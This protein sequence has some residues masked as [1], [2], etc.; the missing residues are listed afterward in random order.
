MNHSHILKSLVVLA[1]ILTPSVL[2]AEEATI[3]VK[4]SDATSIAIKPFGGPEGAAA[5]KIVQNDLDLSGAFLLTPP[6]RASFSVGATAGGGSLAGTVTDSRGS[7]VLQK[8][9]PGSFR[10]AA[11]RFSDD[12]VE[13]ITGTKGIASTKIAFVG[14]RTGRKEIYVADYDGANARQLTSDGSISVAPAISW[15]G[16]KL[17]YTGY[18]SGYADIYAIDLNS[19]A[20]NRII[21]FPGTNSGAAYSPDGGRLA[22]TLSKDGNTELYIVGAAGGGARRLTSTRGVES[23]PAWSPDGNELIYSSDERGGPQLFRIG[24]GGG[25]GRLITTGYG[26]CTEPSW[27]PDGKKVAFNVRQGGFSIAV[28]DLASG[29]TRIVGAGEDPVWGAD[30]R[31]IIYSAGSSINLLDTVKGRI[32]PVVTGA[33]KVSEPSWSR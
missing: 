9:Y 12:I 8:S 21:K 1:A 29:T 31:H 13:T 25:S 7:V 4:K 16:S 32:T 17:A 28:L 27:S 10:T 19:G 14:S 26:Y 11:H 23:S 30:S 6:E 24:A 18:Q 22:C 2:S 3:T 33:G 5:A 15:D 20:R